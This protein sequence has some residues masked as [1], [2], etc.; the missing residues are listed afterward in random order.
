MYVKI[1]LHRIGNG[2]RAALVL[3]RPEFDSPVRREDFHKYALRTLDVAQ[4][5]LV[6]QCLKRRIAASNSNSCRR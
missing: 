2:V 6:R 4:T 1:Y 5:L 3:G